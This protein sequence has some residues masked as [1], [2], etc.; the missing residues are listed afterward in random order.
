MEN[1]N[2]LKFNTFTMHNW[3]LII[4]AE[5]S[6]IVV[7]IAW[8]YSFW[9]T[10]ISIYTDNISQPENPNIFFVIISA[11]FIAWHRKNNLARI[12]PY[13]SQYG[14][15]V[16]LCLTIWWGFNFVADRIFLQQ[17]SVMLMIPAIIFTT[18]GFGVTKQL[19]LPLFLL[20]FTL[21]FG[22]TIYAEIQGLFEN[23]LNKFA[24]FSAVDRSMQIKI[25]DTVTRGLVYIT[26][27]IFAGL[28]ISVIVHTRTIKII[29]STAG[30]IVLP[31]ICNIIS[32]LLVGWIG[33]INHYTNTYSWIAIILGLSLS[34]L[35]VFLIRNTNIGV[36]EFPEFNFLSNIIADRFHW[37]NPTI[38]SCCIM[39]MIPWIA[40]NI[41]HNLW[42]HKNINILLYAPYYLPE[43]SGPF[44][45]PTDVWQPSF[46][47]ATKTVSA[48]YKNQGSSVY[49]YTAY[50]VAPLDTN[51]LTDQHNKLYD[52]KIW[53]SVAASIITIAVNKSISLSLKEEIIHFGDVKRM[54]WSWYY[55][56]TYISP[57]YDVMNLLERVRIISKI[58]DHSGVV[59]MLTEMEDTPDAARARLN[60]FLISLYP[61]VQIL[62]NPI[63]ETLE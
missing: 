15:I 39:L 34:L 49:L 13:C 21:S 30:F 12:A 24:E 18:T 32:I 43:W 2:N 11:V 26:S 59:A 3:N 63:I 17:L 35:F 37:L 14:L 48:M 62:M 20:L 8:L 36:N 45:L 10:I 19:V 52:D 46:I 16:L 33:S 50:F 41:K 42:K 58:S 5:A 53:S 54:I 40:D 60:K 56:G 57:N 38:I 44:N 25:L 23:I 51:G 31:I 47:G 4:S 61:Q 29:V 27:Y 28:I 55:I 7:L 9:P 6:C 1:K 22:H